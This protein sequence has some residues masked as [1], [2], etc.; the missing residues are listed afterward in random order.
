MLTT[1]EKAAARFNE[2]FPEPSTETEI[3]SDDSL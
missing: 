2:I 1:Y 3:N